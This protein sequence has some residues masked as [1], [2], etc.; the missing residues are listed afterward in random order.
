MTK[1]TLIAIFTLFIL[2][3][4]L[5]ASEVVWDGK[6]N[7]I[8]NDKYEK[9]IKQ[10]VYKTYPKKV[11]KWHFQ[12]QQQLYNNRSKLKNIISSYYWSSY[13]DVSDSRNA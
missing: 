3:Y 6:D 4:S 10:Y 11:K 9:I 2:N 1:N 5:I 13:S 7:S 8:S 12:Q